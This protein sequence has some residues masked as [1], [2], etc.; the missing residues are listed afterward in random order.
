MG[1]KATNSLKQMSRNG[2]VKVAVRGASLFSLK[3]ED[4][5]EHENAIWQTHL[6]KGCHFKQLLTLL[7]HQESDLGE[8]DYQINCQR[9]KE[10]N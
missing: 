8:R 4:T 6:K 10:E 1:T 2:T 5:S 3:A 9:K 7:K